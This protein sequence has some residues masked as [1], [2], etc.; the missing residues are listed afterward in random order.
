[1]SKSNRL[2]TTV[3]PE[4]LKAVEKKAAQKRVTVP[5]L[6]RQIVADYIALEPLVHIVDERQLALPQA[7]MEITAW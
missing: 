5:D 6:L 2:F 3:T 1:M 4:L 7:E